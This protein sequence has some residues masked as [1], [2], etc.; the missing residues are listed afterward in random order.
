MQ[1][2]RTVRDA[3]QASFPDL[4]RYNQVGVMQRD[5]IQD[6]I[7][8]FP[9]AHNGT[10]HP[11]AD[12][13][14]NLVWLRVTDS[15]TFGKLGN[16][17]MSSP[18]YASPAVKCETAASGT[19]SWLEPYKDIFW[20]VKWLLVPVLFAVMALV[21]AMAISISVRERRTE[22]AVLKVLGFPPSWVHTTGEAIKVLSAI[23][24]S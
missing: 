12:K 5:Y 21:I 8:A 17:I 16:Q 22:M 9:R 6:A 2:A 10:K 23:E 14:L 7:D 13:N 19:S 4:P 20:G 18:N 3:L 15:E 24:C 11:M 1:V